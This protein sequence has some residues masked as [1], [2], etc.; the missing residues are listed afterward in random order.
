MAAINTKS[1]LT[2]ASRLLSRSTAAACF[3]PARNLHVSAPAR[4]DPP[5]KGPVPTEQTEKVKE[6]GDGFLGVCI[7]SHRILTCRLRC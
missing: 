7:S 3:V 1:A 6:G 4:K 2:S 5:L